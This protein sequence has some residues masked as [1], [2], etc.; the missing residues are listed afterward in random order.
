MYWKGVLTD[1]WKISRDQ[2]V[3][4][5]TSEYRKYQ[6]ENLSPVEKDYLESIKW[7]EK[8]ATSAL[9]KNK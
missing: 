7:L 4:K 5:A 9:K 1:A 8:K 6:A 2:A 3:E